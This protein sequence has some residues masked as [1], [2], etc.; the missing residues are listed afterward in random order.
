MRIKIENYGKN[1]FTIISNVAIRDN[2]LSLTA[3]GLLVYMLSCTDEWVFTFERMQKETN[4]KRQTFTNAMNELI[5]CGYIKKIEQRN[6]GRFS[7]F[8]YEICDEPIFDDR[9]L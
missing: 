7:K 3:R 5:K 8:K 6:G 9:P 1:N 4:T 2:E